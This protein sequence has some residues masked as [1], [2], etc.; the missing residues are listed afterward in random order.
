MH[1]RPLFPVP[2]TLIVHVSHLI[3]TG[4]GPLDTLHVSASILPPSRRILNTR[5]PHTRV[6]A[7]H[8]QCTLTTQAEPVFD[9]PLVPE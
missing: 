2:H 8:R 9:A 5:H 3:L 4:S 1:T 7:S 6:S